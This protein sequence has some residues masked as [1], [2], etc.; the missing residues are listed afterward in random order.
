MGKAVFKRKPTW[1]LFLSAP[2][3]VLSCESP[4]E[5]EFCGATTPPGF[6]VVVGEEVIFQWKDCRLTGLLVYGD[7][8]QV[9]G[10]GGEFK[11]PVTYGVTP[12]G[13]SSLNDPG[14]LVSGQSYEVL[15]ISGSWGGWYEFVR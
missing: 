6:E 8:I 14:T 7:E 1:T 3:L 5:N 15:A 9:W 13:A 10:I 11:S 12:S 2:I 4:T